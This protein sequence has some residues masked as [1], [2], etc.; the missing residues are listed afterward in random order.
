MKLGVNVR[1]DRWHCWV[2]DRGGKTLLTLLRGRDREIYEE[3]LGDVRRN[4]DSGLEKI[5][6]DPY[7]PQGFS[8]VVGSSSRSAAR[9]VEYLSY[10][11]VDVVDMVTYRIGSCDFGRYSG[12]AIFP[13]FDVDGN[14]TYFVARAVDDRLEPKY[15]SDHFSKDIVSN[16]W[17]VD[18]SRPVDLVEG[19][20]DA[21]K[22]GTNS[23]PLYGS[24]LREDTLLFK[25]LT[26]VACGAY[27]ALDG[28]ATKK[29]VRIARLLM[30]Y[31]VPVWWVSM[32]YGE[33]PGGMEK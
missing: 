29:K 26:S 8:C 18:W 23:I 16:E 13:S 30:S 31:G 5:Y 27:V 20:L 6:V 22:A 7:L 25:R 17:M 28:D 32:K 3:Y 10:R 24:S 2:C 33:D 4:D 15:K 9:V 1:T 19:P 21:V 11:G 12:R 14:P